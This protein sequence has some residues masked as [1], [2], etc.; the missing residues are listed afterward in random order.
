MRYGLVFFLLSA[1]ALNAQ[2]PAKIYVFIAGSEPDRIS[3]EA[4]VGTSHGALELTRSTPSFDIES[5]RT[6]ARYCP[7]AV[8]TTR[9]DRADVIIRVERED[10]SPIT[11]FVKA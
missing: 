10:S 6:F 8:I 4:V 5:M 11:P 3:G 9:Q 1:A 2:S 7:S